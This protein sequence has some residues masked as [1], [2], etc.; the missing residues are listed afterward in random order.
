M[1][2][3][4][5]LAVLMALGLAR[6]KALSADNE[7]LTARAQALAADNARLADELQNNLAAL[8]VRE[9]V[10]L[11]LA[12]E[13]DDLKFKLGELYAKDTLAADWS[14]ADLPDDLVDCLLETLPGPDSARV[15]ACGLV[16]GGARTQ[17]ARAKQP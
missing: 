13:T 9:N 15:A 4:I 7:R 14:N 5:L 16:A 10:R 6:L 11:Q 3:V 12:A 8:A 2:A 1:M 17:T